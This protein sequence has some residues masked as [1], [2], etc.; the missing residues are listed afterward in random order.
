MDPISVTRWLEHLARH[1]PI[2]RSGGD[3]EGVHQVRVACGRLGV[4]LELARWWVV[5]DDLRWLRGSAGRVRELDV[6]LA[7]ELP[8]DFAAWLEERR[9]EEREEMLATLD[10][11]RLAGLLTALAQ[12][13]PID[14]ERARARLVRFEQRAARKG[15]ALEAHPENVERY[16]ALRKSLRRVRYAMEALGED[17]RPIKS[18][19]SCLGLMNDAAVALDLLDEYPGAG[20]HGELREHYEERVEEQRRR[21]LERWQRSSLRSE[22]HV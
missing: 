16:H 14:P 21:A 8:E 1:L 5:V 6:L 18:L 2:A 13:P 7:D 15:R 9:R 10:H 11:P 17:P 12:L 3:P 20:A 19:Q 22:A 4:W